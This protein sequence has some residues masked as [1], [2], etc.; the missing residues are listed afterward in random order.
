[1]ED[2]RVE[3][4]R[5]F[6]GTTLCNVRFKN[7]IFFLK[8]HTKNEAGRRVPGLFFYYK[9]CYIYEVKASG[10]QLSFNIFWKTST[11]KNKLHETLDYWSRDILNFDFSE[12]GLGSCSTAFCVWIFKKH[13]SH[14]YSIN[15]PY[16]IAWLPLLLE[17]LINT[18]IVIV[19]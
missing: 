14:V 10:L 8:N 9:K 11:C 2:N 13:V 16:Y 18:C 7:K 12:K 1:M 15:W 3:S 6:N 4:T 5:N 19:W 17:I